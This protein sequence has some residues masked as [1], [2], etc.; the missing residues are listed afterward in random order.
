MLHSAGLKDPPLQ[1]LGRYSAGLKTR[2]LR[3]PQ[4]RGGAS[5]PPARPS[6]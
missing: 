4:G 2:P 6:V 1:D 3:R 5:D